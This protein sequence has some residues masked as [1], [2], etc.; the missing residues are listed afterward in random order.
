MEKFVKLDIF[1]FF[2]LKNCFVQYDFEGY[3]IESLIKHES[4]C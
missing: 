3:S 1:K 2:F 4:K